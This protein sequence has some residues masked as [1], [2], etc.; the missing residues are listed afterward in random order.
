LLYLWAQD[1]R[2]IRF[3]WW[4]DPVPCWY[5]AES[6]PQDVRQR[7]QRVKAARQDLGFDN[8]SRYDLEDALWGKRGRFSRTYRL[9]PPVFGR[10]FTSPMLQ[11]DQIG[12]RYYLHG[13][14]WH[15]PD[16]IRALHEIARAP[17]EY[18]VYSARPTVIEAY[19]QWKRS[20]SQRWPFTTESNSDAEPP[21][22]SEVLVYIGGAII[23]KVHPEDHYMWSWRP[24]APW[25][26]YKEGPH[27]TGSLL[28]KERDSL[29]TVG[30]KLLDI[31]F[32][33]QQGGGRRFGTAEDFKQAVLDAIQ[34]LR[35]SG[36][37]V[38]K[39]AIGRHIGRTYSPSYLDDD[40][41]LKDPASKS[42][43]G[44]VSSRSMSM[45]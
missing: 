42:P 12:E 39:T 33:G 8:F 20:I 28:K 26:G 30:R 17:L 13:L 25:L 7:L 27:Q 14:S 38:S 9:M 19:P 11:E 32:R 1:H 34:E 10:P 35:E 15:P 5:C 41:T 21:V 22:R 29:F 3:G 36:Q 45:H 43:G 31:H 44:H 23:P 4:G 18:A 2:D 24:E 6:A 16:Q 40:P 37:R